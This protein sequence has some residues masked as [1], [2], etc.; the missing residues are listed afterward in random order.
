MRYIPKHIKFIFLVYLIGLLFFTA[1]RLILLFVEWK[2]LEIIPGASWLILQSFFMGFRFDTVISGYFLALPLVVLS[3]TSGFN[4]NKKWLRKTICIFIIVVYSLGF[5][6]CAADIPFFR[7]YFTRLNFTIFN[8]ANTPGFVL[9]MIFQETSYFIFFFLFLLIT[10][11]YAIIILKLN[12]KILATKSDFDIKES[13]RIIIHVSVSVLACLLMFV[14]IRGRL[15]TKSPIKAGTAFFSNYAFPNQL[16]LNPVFTFIRSY[17]DA[18]KPENKTLQLM[19]DQLA[20]KNVQQYFTIPKNSSIESP[21]ARV[22]LADST[23]VKANVIVVIMESMSAE[24]MQRYGNTNNLTPFLDSIANHSYTFENIYTSGIHTFNGIYSTLFSFPALLKQHPMNVT[25]IPEYTGF[26]NTLSVNGYHTIY[27]TTH[28]EQ[29]DNV[30]GFL[31]ANAIEEIVSQKDYPSEKVL[32]T[33]GVPDDYMFEYAIPKLNSLNKKGS[34]FFATFMTASDHGPYIIPDNIPFHPHS[35][36][37][38]QQIVEYADWSLKKFLSLAGK[39]SWFKNTFFVFVADHGC[40]I[41]YSPYDMPLC[42]N[43]IPF[44]I[45]AP[46]LITKEE[47]FQQVGGQMDIFPTLM[48]LLNISYVNNTFGIDLRKEKRPYIYFSADD[49]IGCLNNDWYWEYHT[50]G[51]QSLYKYQNYDSKDYLS[52]NKIKADSMKTYVFSML[53]C[54]QWM[55]K[56]G[57]TGEEKTN[58]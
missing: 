32:S 28:D 3:I 31:K 51:S 40:F 44:I 25:M 21:I 1:F 49:K 11:L 22:I 35:T 17:L 53:Q 48:G 57:K 41:G 26:P 29:F 18:L 30:S 42:Y 4:Y 15:E 13:N 36:E 23:P 50:D 19:N 47:S 8:W 2:Q 33:L 27:F 58:K 20:I 24:K 6:I 52:A 14:G 12:K 38:K 43:H 9:K 5:L 10:I 37:I 56:H 39:Q 54:A 7:Q 16:G 45:Y 34:P 55:I 46:D